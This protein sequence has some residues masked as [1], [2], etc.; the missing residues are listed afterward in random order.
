MIEQL[1]MGE[2]GV[3]TVMDLLREADQRAT[4]ILIRYKD[5]LQEIAEHLYE[6]GTIS[7]EELVLRET[8]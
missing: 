7:V 2:F 5:R 3:T 6:K 4:E 1:A 8:E